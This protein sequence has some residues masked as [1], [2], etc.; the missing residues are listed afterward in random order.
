MNQVLKLQQE[1]RV[2]DEFIRDG[3]NELISDYDMQGY[4]GVY[5]D[6]YEEAPRTAPRTGR[7][8]GQRR[9]RNRRRRRKSRPQL[10]CLIA[11][12]S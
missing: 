1:L 9:Q 4:T 6:I 12:P 5:N 3:G 8:E 10:T 11:Y 7:S 2:H